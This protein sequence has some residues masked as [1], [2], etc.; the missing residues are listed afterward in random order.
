MRQNVVRIGREVAEAC[1]E[2]GFFV[3][4]ALKSLRFWHRDPPILT[5]ADLAKFAEAR[6]KFVSQ[7][8]LFGYIKA[9]AGTRYTLLFTDDIYAKSINIAKW[10]IY[11]SCLGDIAVFL[12]ARI[13]SR[14]GASVEEVRAMALHMVD[15]ILTGEEIPAD[16]PQGFADIHTKF[17]ERAQIAQWA[18]CADGEAAFMGSIAALT[19]WAPIADELK[20]LDQRIVRNSIRFKWKQVRDQ[21]D[22]LLDP[23]AVIADWRAGGRATVEVAN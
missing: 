11:L 8:T 15:V 2:A 3:S 19:E 10:E 21:V 23:D 13:G 14:T 7:I 20:S 1:R 6:A 22:V 4:L 17:Q 5:V 18:D 16:R 12:A 9:R